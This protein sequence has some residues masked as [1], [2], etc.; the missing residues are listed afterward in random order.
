MANQ[1]A[2]DQV[3]IGIWISASLGQK[4][5]SARKGTPRSQWVRDAIA[6]LLRSEGFEVSDSESSAPARVRTDFAKKINSAK[7][8]AAA[9]KIEE[10]LK[11]TIRNR[12]KS[13]A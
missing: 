9:D 1:R 12:R 5:E 10:E 8:Q 11:R 6:A 7:V 3:F 2:A 4:I 13:A